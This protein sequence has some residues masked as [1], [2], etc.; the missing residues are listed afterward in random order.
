MKIYSLAYHIRIAN[1]P[2]IFPYGRNRKYLSTGTQPKWW[3][4]F[5]L[6]RH[7]SLRSRIKKKLDIKKK[8]HLTEEGLGG[9]IGGGGC[10]WRVIVVFAVEEKRRLVIKK[11]EQ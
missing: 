10:S 11:E 7:H 2:H 5:K 6:A 8:Q 4:Q 1:Q 3:T 9:K